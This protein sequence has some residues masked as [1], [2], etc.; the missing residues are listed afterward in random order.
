MQPSVPSP[1]AP[2]S[3]SA[4]PQLP[5]AI[6]AAYRQYEAG[7]DVYFNVSADEDYGKLC[8][9]DPEQLEAGSRIEVAQFLN[10]GQGHDGPHCFAPIAFC[11]G[12][13]VSPAVSP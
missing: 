13:G 4:S 8:N 10:G 12:L 2:P 1:S 6:R 5:P 9:R 11:S 7:G 3:V